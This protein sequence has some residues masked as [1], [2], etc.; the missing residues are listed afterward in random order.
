MNGI[1]SPRFC[2]LHT[3]IIQKKMM[4]KMLTVLLA[5][6]VFAF[7]QEQ[8]NSNVSEV[9][10]TVKQADGYKI[11]GVANGYP[12]GTVVDLLNGN[13][14]AAEATTT[15]SAGKFELSG[16]LSSP[17]FKLL[18]FDKSPNF[19]PIFLDNSNV[20]VNITKDR[21][22]QTLVS[23]SASHNDFI[24][25]SNVSKPYESL[26]QQE[27]AKDPEMVR[28]CAQALLNFIQ[29]K[30]GSFIA[31]LAIFRIHQVTG[32][33]GLMEKL[34]AGLTPEVKKSP[35]GEYVGQQVDEGKRD[36]MG[37][38]IADFEQEDQNGKMVNI[39]SFRG[40]YVLIDF[41][42]SWCGPCRGENP[43]VVAAFNKYK[44]KNFTVL[45]I[46][47]D[48][49]KSPW[50][51]A[52]KKDGLTWTQLSDLKGWSNAVSQQFG[53][54]S[55]PQN[56]LIDPNGVVIAKNLRGAALEAKLES[57]LK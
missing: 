22:D 28:Q 37:K 44:S 8:T 52:I 5:L 2:I 56:F 39:Q 49:T 7:A 16:K 46:S 34:Y 47:L 25:Y 24:E 6:P 17:D 1:K 36:P 3:I 57:L 33:N 11:N 42:A 55:I 20:I 31:P 53:I 51:E 30:R 21:P 9:K 13:N 14:R 12:D 23:G 48:K 35:I 15:V 43:N 40:K 45:G 29:N 27:G 26:F 32:D 10:T 18:V 54:T 41:W 38:V 4:K 19:I 50:L